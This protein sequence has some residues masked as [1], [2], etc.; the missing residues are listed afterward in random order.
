MPLSIGFCIHP[1]PTCHPPP[2]L[3]PLLATLTIDYYLRPIFLFLAFIP[4]SFH[5]PPTFLPPSSH[6]LPPPSFLT[7]DF[8]IPT[9]LLSLIGGFHWLLLLRVLIIP[10]SMAAP[11]RVTSVTYFGLLIECVWD[12]HTDLPWLSPAICGGSGRLRDA[13]G[14]SGMLREALRPPGGFFI[15][16]QPLALNV[17]IAF[18]G[19][20]STV[21]VVVVVVVVAT[22]IHLL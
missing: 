11:S 20:F 1:L 5:L 6:L 14:C 13:P 2:T 15:D 3:P 18:D 22:L 19:S 4:P 8:N 16:R 21:V 7:I 9:C 17:A 12:L 10:E